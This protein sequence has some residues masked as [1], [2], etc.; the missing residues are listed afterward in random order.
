MLVNV[1]EAVPDE[2]FVFVNFSSP[3]AAHN[4]KIGSYPSAAVSAWMDEE[5]TKKYQE[6]TISYLPFGPCGRDPIAISPYCLTAINDYRVEHDAETHRINNFPR[7]PS[8]LSATYAF[9]DEKTCELVS[10]KYGWDLGTVRK[11]R[12]LPHPLNRVAKVNMEH[13]SLARH[14]YRVSAMQS[15]E[16]I[17][18]AYW[19]GVGNIKIELPDGE[20]FS[21]NIR[22]SGEIWEFLVEGCLQPVA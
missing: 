9:G 18:D 1:E 20:N 11:F 5:L 6:G 7:Y 2:F 4:Y 13:V 16:K 21:R 12:L 15:V 14:A 17:W 3:L 8:R 22:E 19:T 10:R